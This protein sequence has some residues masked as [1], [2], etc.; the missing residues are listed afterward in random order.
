MCSIAVYL[1]RK[2]DLTWLDLSM[3]K[4]KII[5]TRHQNRTL[6]DENISLGKYNVEGWCVDLIN[7]HTAVFVL[8]LRHW[9]CK[10]Y[11]FC[12][13]FYDRLLGSR[14]FAYKYGG[15]GTCVATLRW[16]QKK[17]FFYQRGV[18]R[19]KHLRALGLHDRSGIVDITWDLPRRPEWWVNPL[20]IIVTKLDERYPSIRRASLFLPGMRNDV[21]EAQTWL[22]KTC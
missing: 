8:R 21:S 14:L 10:F 1:Q 9:P 11:L 12:N 18:A 7:D 13:K 16:S 2:H 15:R 5:V 3:K 6:G 20:L 19:K 17:C 22:V 4:S